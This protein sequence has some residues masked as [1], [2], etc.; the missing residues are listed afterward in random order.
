[1][2]I[3]QQCHGILRQLRVAVIAVVLL[4]AMVAAAT[5][6]SAQSSLL[7]GIQNASSTPPPG[8]DLPAV[9]PLPLSSAQQPPGSASTP[10]PTPGVEL[11]ARTVPILPIRQYM[12][13]DVQASRAIDAQ[14]RLAQ[15]CMQSFGLDFNP[16]AP[17]PKT[18]AAEIDRVNRRYGITNIDTARVFGYHPPADIV[19][20]S[21]NQPLL[22]NTLDPDRKLVFFGPPRDSPDI[23]PRPSY[24]GRPV[25][26]EGCIGD[27]SRQIA[28]TGEF[29][30]VEL[31][32]QIDRDSMDASLRDS[33]VTAVIGQ[34]SACMK[35]AGYTY[36][37][38]YKA[39]ADRRWYTPAPTQPEIT[40]ALADITCKD[41]THLINIWSGVE[42]TYQLKQI[43]DHNAELSAVEQDKQH[44]FDVIN[45]V[46]GS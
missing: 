10:R 37:D 42:R 24:H 22:I 20:T 46:L 41:R 3:Q 13:T 25:P 27:A 16:P 31:A 2:R 36:L 8:A 5:A 45:S 26:F 6:C 35:Q 28:G 12:F 29:G 23:K 19:T 17:M 14:Y 4:M 30:H 7:Q 1:M 43:A 44:Q 21:D 39:G 32:A 11:P 18:E 38:P 9:P 33:Q 15:K 34:W 40:A